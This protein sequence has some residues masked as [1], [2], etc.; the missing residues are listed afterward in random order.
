MHWTRV[1]ALFTVCLMLGRM[2]QPWLRLS[3]FGQTDAIAAAIA[4]DR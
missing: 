1:L 3:P 2:L 4:V